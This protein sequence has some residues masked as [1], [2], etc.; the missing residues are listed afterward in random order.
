MLEAIPTQANISI[1]TPIAQFMIFIDLILKRERTLL[2]ACV[3]P[4]HQP[5]APAAIKIYPIATYG[6]AMSG[7][8]KLNRANRPI[9][10]KII[11]GFENVKRNPPRIFFFADTFCGMGRRSGEAGSFRKR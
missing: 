6:A 3:M 5:N 11:R 7:E 10:R 2:M 9:I 4:N 1:T 8:V